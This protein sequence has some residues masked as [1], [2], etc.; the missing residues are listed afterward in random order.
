MHVRF[1]R[2]PWRALNTD[3]DGIPA[4]EELDDVV[5]PE[6]TFQVLEA[7]SSQQEAIEAAKGRASFVLQGPPGTGK[8]DFLPPLKG[9]PFGRS[10]SMPISIGIG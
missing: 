2:S 5:D 3:T 4:A 7:D 10:L 9:S 8:I 6:E 1:V